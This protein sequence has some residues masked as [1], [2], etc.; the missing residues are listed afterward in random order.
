MKEEVNSDTVNND[1]GNDNNETNNNE[2][3][4][5]DNQT[6]SLSLL[7]R[8]AIFRRSRKMCYVRLFPNEIGSAKLLVFG[9][10]FINMH[11]ANI[12]EVKHG[13]CSFTLTNSGKK[14][15]VKFRD[16]HRLC[17]FLSLLDTICYGSIMSDHLNVDSGGMVSNNDDC[18]TISTDDENSM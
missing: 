7:L 2:R 18:S 1:D 9:K 11:S 10:H 5:N 14:Y 8:S 15:Y 4:R 3:N 12:Q 13:D 16:V 6:V 17:V